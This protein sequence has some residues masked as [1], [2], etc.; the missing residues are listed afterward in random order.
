MIEL[1]P[2]PPEIFT[3]LGSP[4]GIM[5]SWLEDFEFPIQVERS[6]DTEAWTTI[7][8]RPIEEFEWLDTTPAQGQTW[9]YRLRSVRE[10]TVGVAIIGEASV[11]VSVDHPDVYPPERPRDLVCLPEG[12]QVR[13]RWA[14]APPEIRFRIERKVNTGKSKAIT[15]DEEINQYLDEAPPYGTLVYTIRAVDP[16]GNLSESISCETLIGAAP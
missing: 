11:V 16:A 3:A 7:S 4:E 1:P 10:G 15:S 8:T 13:L 9:Y 12:S 6:P 2:E 5:L 14:S